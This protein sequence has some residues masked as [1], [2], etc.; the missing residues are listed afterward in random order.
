MSVFRDRQ[1]HELEDFCRRSRT[2][3]KGAASPFNHFLEP[4]PDHL[5][6]IAVGLA[7]RRARL[8]FVYSILRGKDLETGE[9]SDARREEQFEKLQAA[10]DYALNLQHWQDFFKC[11]MRA[12]FRSS[13]FIS[14]RN[15]IIYSYVLYLIGRRDFGLKGHGLR[16]AIARWFFFASLTGRY[17]GSPE[18]AMEEDLANLRGATDPEE[19]T[20]YID[21][22]I[23]AAFT[24]DYWEITLPNELTSSAARS[25]SLF[26]YYAALN[27]LDAR[28]LFSDLK[29]PQLMDPIIQGARSNLERHHLFP[30]AYLQRNGYKSVRETNQ[31]ANFALIEWEANADISDEAPAE[32]WPRYEHFVDDD[33]RYWHALPE[34]WQ[35]L[36]YLDFLER[37]RALIA[38]VIREGSETL[39]HQAREASDER[40]GVA[41]LSS[42]DRWLRELPAEV[43]RH[44]EVLLEEPEQ[45]SRRLVD[46]VTAYLKDLEGH[47]RFEPDLDI[48]TARA[49][50]HHCERLLERA[51]TAGDAELQRVA[52][53][54]ALY[55]VLDSDADSD[56]HSPSGFD[57]DLQV[58]R[59]AA[60]VVGV[61]QPV[62][63]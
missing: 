17:T 52:Q 49:V 11:L 5:L 32:Y 44:V 6:R 33:V 39:N 19:F 15:T 59:T 29:V 9:F 14:S 24:S 3:A 37:R 55:F 18:S 2:P 35:A 20:G 12:G 57:D 63:D 31:I 58:V 53:A 56:I 34:D 28:A 40:L 21:K 1:R 13:K 26:A 45:E 46:E 62:A 51:E 41:E 7:F 16:T 8:E 42:T 50:A 38:R 23:G 60:E 4:D 30:R 27:L 22:T 61:E 25:P 43:R 36:D 47:R 48:E 10:Q 54:S